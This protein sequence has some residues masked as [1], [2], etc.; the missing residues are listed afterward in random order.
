MDLKPLALNL[1][2]S[3]AFPARRRIAYERLLLEAI[4]NDTTLFVRRD[5]AE[6]AWA[7]I[8]AVVHGWQKTGMKPNPYPA[9]SWGPAGAFA[10][11]ERDG[12]S[13]YE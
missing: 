5:E 7:W 1:S 11:I 8:D 12:R 2:L 6:A 4:K 10:L 3:D 13:W 9:G